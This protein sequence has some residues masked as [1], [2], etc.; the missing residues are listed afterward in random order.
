MSMIS[1][2][3]VAVLD[4]QRRAADLINGDQVKIL[5]TGVAVGSHHY[6]AL[7]NLAQGVD[8]VSF[9]LSNASFRLKPTDLVTVGVPTL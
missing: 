8:W 4:V 2:N 5:L 9:Q 1:T 3:P 7:S 6:Y